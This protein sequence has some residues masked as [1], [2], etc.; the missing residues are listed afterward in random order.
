MSL[1]ENTVVID[2]LN[3][4]AETREVFEAMRRGGI[5]AANWTCVSWES[6]AATLHN[7]AAW[8][9]R[10][11]DHADLIAQ[12]YTTEDIRRAKQEGKLGIFIGWQNSSGYDDY[13]PF[14]AIF[15]ELGVRVVQLTYNTANAVGSGCYESEDRGLTDFGHDLVAELNRNAVLIDLSH[16]G[17]RTTAETIRAS[18]RP[19]CHSHTL[20]AALRPHPRN[21]SDEELRLLAQHGGFVGATA[22]PAFLR[23]GNES[24]IED[25]VDAIEHLINVV[26][27]RQVGIGTDYTEGRSPE[28][29]VPIS[30]DKGYGRRLRDDAAGYI[31]EAIGRLDSL[32]PALA[33]EMDRR[34][35]KQSRI[36]GLLGENWLRFLDDAWLKA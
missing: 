14:V 26:G 31:P 34:G 18:K 21:K 36:E 20:P 16:T 29:F 9:Q 24:T 11:V 27:E 15:A 6:C 17:A 12:V 19:V 7:V 35:W 22:F 2:G 1:F 30:L 23:R 28:F 3:T 4:S 25:Y 13:L 32:F 5:D 8:K 10:F 33:A